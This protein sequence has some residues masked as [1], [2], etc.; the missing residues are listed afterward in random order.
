LRFSNLV[1]ETQSSSALCAIGLKAPIWKKG[2]FR[3]GAHTT[4]KV[5][6]Y[7]GEVSESA[8]GHTKEE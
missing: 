2:D 8:S 3:L 4:P 5:G 7:A 6:R 1:F